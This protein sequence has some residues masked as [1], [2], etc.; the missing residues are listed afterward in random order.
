MY[1]VPKYNIEEYVVYDGKIYKITS[2]HA[3]NLSLRIPF[4]YGLILAHTKPQEPYAHKEL[5]IRECLLQKAS[6]AQVGIWKTLYGR[7]R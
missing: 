3:P 5:Y 6:V 4:V 2:I 1:L 7:I